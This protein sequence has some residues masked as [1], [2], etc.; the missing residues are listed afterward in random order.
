VD[1]GKSL[2]A[3]LLAQ[4]PA[5]KSG[6]LTNWDPLEVSGLEIRL[7]KGVTES[8]TDM[9]VCMYVCMYVYTYVCMYVCAYVCIYI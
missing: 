4:P 8:V 1:F 9:Y 7:V 2:C 5:L 3:G 6:V